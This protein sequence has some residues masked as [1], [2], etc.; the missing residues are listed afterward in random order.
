MSFLVRC[1]LVLALGIVPL[2]SGAGDLVMGGVYSCA[3]IPPFISKLQLTQPVII[4]TTAVRRP[5]LVLREAREG[6][7]SYQHGSWKITGHTGATVRDAQGNIYVIPVPSVGLDTNPLER[8][9]IVYK[10]DAHSGVMDEFVRLPLPATTTQRNPFGTVGLALDCETNSLYVSSV[11][12]STAQK[13]AGVIY[14]INLANGEIL[15]QL[16][17]IDAIGLGVFNFTQQKVLFYGDARSSSVLSVPLSST[18]GFNQTAKPSF[19]LSL[20][21]IKNGDSTQVRKFR[22]S[23]QQNQHKMIVSDTEFSFRL[24]AERGKSS[25]HYS[26]VWSNENKRW[27]Q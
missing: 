21:N 25:K 16:D 6:G 2:V 1:A 24:A 26:F 23:Y 13:I 27:Q 4:D 20:L 18:G 15:D 19:R 8:R 11:A 9:N 10:V 7:R 17:G 14:Q 3:K 22:F 12:A 5:G